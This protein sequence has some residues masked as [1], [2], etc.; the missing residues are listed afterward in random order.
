MFRY[1]YFIRIAAMILSVAILLCV[2]CG[3]DGDA[4]YNWKD[5][6]NLRTQLYHASLETDNEIEINNNDDA[7]MVLAYSADDEMNPYTC[8]STLTQNIC[9]LLYDSLF[10]INPNF[11]PEYVIAKSITVDHTI[12][13]VQ[14]RS[15]IV[16][17]DGSALTGEDVSYSYYM[18]AK[19][20]GSIYASKLAGVTSCSV[21]GMT[22]TFMMEDDNVNAYKMLDFP[23]IKYDLSAN[24]DFP[25]LGSGRYKF[26]TLSDGV[27]P[28]TTLLVKNDKWYNPEKVQIQSILLREMPT[29][30]S[31]VHS[32]EIGTVSYMY[33]DMRDGTPQNVNANYQKV[34]I[35][36]LIYI[37]INTNDTALADENVRRAMYYAVSTNEVATVG[38]SG[39]ALGA[40]GP[41]TPNWSEA[42][43]YQTGNGRSQV[44]SATE[45]LEQSGYVISNGG[46]RQDQSGKQLTF[47][48]LVSKDNDSHLAAA[49]NIKSQLAKVGINVE[50]TEISA[51]GLVKRVSEGQYHLYL[52]EYSILNDMD[53][54]DLFTPGEGLYNGPQ[55]YDSVRT[56]DNY[57]KGEGTLE[58][59]INAFEGEL[60]FIPICYR[61]GI[62]VYKRSLEGV[63]EV[64]E[65][66]PFYN[67]QNWFV[68]TSD[69]EN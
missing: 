25:P 66:Q 63:G 15:G 2:M 6:E 64:S 17:S 42:A 69:D 30:E 3:C 8:T 16:F 22:V 52:A 32:I 57:I 56:Y 38:F 29:V 5:S 36:N 14:V 27:T 13:T 62:I 9:Y 28:N 24:K 10:V 20:K 60:P 19:T 26:A 12:V 21:N 40:T 61:M 51:G 65:D 67:M 58:E 43:Q 33:S 44:N 7:D 47:N 53:I 34:D 4:N 48:M 55:P 23:I 59:F 11:E 68:N 37:G 18:A 54:G 31:I 46:I 35:N 39:M 49:E 1:K 50:I 41:F 45:C